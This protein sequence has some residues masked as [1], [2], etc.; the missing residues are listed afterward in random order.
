MDITAL[1]TLCVQQKASDLHL[2]TGQ[3]PLV[4]IDGELQRLQAPPLEAVDINTWLKALLSEAQR[5]TYKQNLE[6]D[7]AFAL[8]GLGRFRCNIFNHQR[9]PGAVIRLIPA[10][11][12]VLEQLCPDQPSLSTS[13]HRL[14]ALKSGLILVTGATGSG[15]STTLAALLNLINASQ[16]V[17]ILTLEDPIEF[18]YQPQLALVNQREIYRDSLGFAPALRSAL[19]EDPDVILIGELRD[20]ETTRLALSAAETGHKVF[21]T[22]HTRNAATSI[23]RLIDMFPAGEKP[24]IRSM[25][26]ESLQAVIA[27]AL[28]PK[29]TGGRIAAYELMLGTPAIRNLIREDKTAQIYSSIQTGASQGMQ[30]LDQALQQ[31]V[32]NQAINQATAQAYARQPEAFA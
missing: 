16:K 1:L 17:H 10:Q 3:P 24:L 7:L 4:R 26:A 14:A 18:I 12:P 29:S 25:L 20:L 21:A 9:G 27:Q 11:I 15:K 28:V 23:N 6:T 5:H 8:P 13:L 31:L 22:L 30:T 19:R 2:S 32:A